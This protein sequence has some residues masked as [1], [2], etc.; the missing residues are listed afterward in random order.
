M[1]ASCN[2]RISGV[3]L[4]ILP[5]ESV[6]QGVATALRSRMVT[7]GTAFFAMGASSLERVNPPDPS[8]DL[9]LPCCPYLLRYPSIK[10]EWLSP[11]RQTDHLEGFVSEVLNHSS[12]E[13]LMSH[14]GSKNQRG[15]PVV[16]QRWRS[17]YCRTPATTDRGAPFFFWGVPQLG[18]LKTSPE[19]KTDL[20]KI[21]TLRRIR[22]IPCG[23]GTQRESG[24]THGVSIPDDF[25]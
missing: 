23:L 14:A 24:K 19:K 15:T 7:F 4:S 16:I 5:I 17:S 6:S 9:T 20:E 21:K 12:C 8:G 25:G 3:A 18:E 11:V 22:R 1:F 2:T 13:C 10:E